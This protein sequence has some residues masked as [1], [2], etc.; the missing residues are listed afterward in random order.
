[1]RR[2]LWYGNSSGSDRNP[3]SSDN[4]VCL[5]VQSYGTYCQQPPHN[6]FHLQSTSNYLKQSSDSQTSPET[7]TGFLGFPIKLALLPMITLPNCLTP[8]ILLFPNSP[9]KLKASKLR[10]IVFDHA[11]SLPLHI[12]LQLIPSTMLTELIYLIYITG[13]LDCTSHL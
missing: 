13:D 2:L 9:P 6:C 10:H 11:Q 7:T 12:I 3:N 8:P 1:M 5:S 4:P